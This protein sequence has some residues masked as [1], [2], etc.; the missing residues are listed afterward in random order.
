MAFAIWIKTESSDIYVYALDG[1]PTKKEIV[2]LLKERLG[3]EFE[4]I[5]DYKFDATYNIKFT[6]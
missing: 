2:S 6:L 3:E 5:A 4:Y 1:N